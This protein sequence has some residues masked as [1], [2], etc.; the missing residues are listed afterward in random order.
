MTVRAGCVSDG[1][2][3]NAVAYTSGSEGVRERE[4][5]VL[6]SLRPV[7]SGSMLQ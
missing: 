5:W 6:S 7:V 1:A 3:E 4:R 2:L